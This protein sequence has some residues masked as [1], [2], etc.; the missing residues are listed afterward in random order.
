[1]LGF[2]RQFAAPTRHRLAAAA[3]LILALGLATSA[4]GAPN[5]NA[6][7]DMVQLRSGQVVPGRYIVVL[8][9]DVADA[10]A[11]ALALAATHGLDLRFIYT[12]ALKGFSA[13]FSEQA[14]AALARDPRVDFVEPDRTVSLFAHAGTAT[15]T[16][17][18][19]AFAPGNSN[20]TINGV[21]DYRIDV[22][23]AVIDTGIDFDHPDLN[24]VGRVDCSGGGPFGGGTC[25]D[26]KGD[27]GNGHGTHVAGTIGAL[28]NGAGVVGMAPGARLWAVKVLG[29]NGSGYISWI[30]GG[31]D[32]VTANADIIEVANMSLGCECSSAAMDIAIAT[33]VAAGV[34]YA[35]SAGN[36]DRDAGAFSPANHPD[37][38]TVSALADFDGVPGGLGS[39]TCRN[40]QDDTLAD[41]SNWGAD[42]EIAAPG[43]CIESTWKGG[44]YNTISGTSMASPHV[45]GAAALLAASGVSIPTPAQIR[46]TL[47]ATGNNVWTDDSG[48]GVKEPLLDVG[49]AA[50]FAPATVAGPESGGTVNIPPTVTIGSPGSDA[51]YDSGASIS[52]AGTASDAED[53]D[54]TGDL[55]WTANGAPIGTGGS[56][57]ATLA[58][59]SY[60]ITATATDLGD[61]SG[62]DVK[63]S[64]DS[65]SITVGTP[66]AGAVDS[67]AY[68]TSGGRSR[69][70]HLNVFI[71]TVDEA[72]APLAGASISIK[73]VR[74]EGGEWPASGLTDENGTIGFTLKNAAAGCYSTEVTDLNGQ[75][76]ITPN[77]SLCK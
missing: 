45:A 31:I 37:V 68:S 76:P 34:T 46:T 16:G 35:V 41:F 44:G 51:L 70:K 17:I 25:D 1:M 13:G 29:N 57:P 58:D 18:H 77:N 2:V 54:L 69:D 8:R 27:D 5:G 65:V 52:F 50:V 21:D 23:V 6:G 67:I 43:V 7:R 73:L 39:S 71:S 66:P 47:M 22:D 10:R 24:V 30:V 32:W 74:A 53:G 62:N 56:F 12:A 64:S 36:S 20:L 40:D 63:S 75:V 55:T 72:D 59:G 49:N 48:D 60:A 3:T 19:R 61:G 42:V 11:A 38:I 9:D 33:S 4:A 26:N 14:A 15:P 28:D